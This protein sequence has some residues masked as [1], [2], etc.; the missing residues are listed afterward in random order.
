MKTTL[1]GKDLIDIGYKQGPAISLALEAMEKMKHS[2]NEE[3]IATAEDVLVNPDAYREQEYWNRVVDKL[4]PPKSVN[5]LRETAVPVQIYGQHLIEMGAYNQIYQAAKL[6]VSYKAALMPDAHSGYGLP[7]GGVLATEN[8]I[9]PYGVGVDIG[10]RMALTIY[11]MR[12]LEGQN[13]VELIN[14]LD[15]N[16]FF[17]AG[18]ER[19]KMAEHE[20]ME[21]S[22]F[23]MNNTIKNLKDRAAKQLGTS[24]SGNHFVEWGIVEFA[25]DDLLPAG[26]YLGLLSHSGSRGLGANI[27]KYYTDKAMKLR[28]LDTTYSRLAWLM[29]DEEEGMEYWLAMNLAGDYAKACHDVIHQS[30]A[31]AIGERPLL[32]IEN[33]HNFAWR[34]QH[35]GKDLIVH[36]KGATPAGQGVMGIIPGSMATPGYVVRGLGVADSLNSA[37]HGAG[38][39]MSRSAAKQQFVWGN[40]R[41]TLDERGIHLM[42]GGVDECYGAYKD[43]QTV[44]AAQSNLIDIIAKF[45]PKIVRMAG[46]DEEPED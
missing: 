16:T 37:S 9:I 41:R 29:M 8:A 35:D 10:C 42:G 46:S 32:K 18:V 33:H 17:G 27:A 24:G 25:H 39:T 26:R 7:I 23:Q 19:P 14:A 3:R 43:I 11:P 5:A 31:K 22:V 1:R 4:Y 20:V 40:E 2:S 6:P 13:R 12:E 36:R 45:D 30:I 44:M 34:E 15:K 38:R 21:S 28:K